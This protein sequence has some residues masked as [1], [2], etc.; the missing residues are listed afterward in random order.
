MTS[1]DLS[2][3]IVMAATI[4]TGDSY[5]VVQLSMHLLNQDCRQP[6]LCDPT[7]SMVTYS[8]SPQD[9]GQAPS[10]IWRR[11]VTMMWPCRPE[12]LEFD[13]G[14]RHGRWRPIAHRKHISLAHLPLFEILRSFSDAIVTND[15]MRSSNLV[16]DSPTP[17]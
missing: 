13:R 2:E 10:T 5:T 17:P 3:I 15:E 4:A 12:R 8:G 9:F 16:N 7:V 6:R 14:W 1:T 11:E